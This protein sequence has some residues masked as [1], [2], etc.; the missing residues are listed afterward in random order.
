MIRNSCAAAAGRAPSAACA[1]TG[2]STVAAPATAASTAAVAAAPRHIVLY[3][4]TLPPSPFASDRVRCVAH[5]ASILH[6]GG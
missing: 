3:P 2:P 1:R 4:F 5:A 6:H